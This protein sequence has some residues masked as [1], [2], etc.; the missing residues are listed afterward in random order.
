MRRKER[1]RK[2]G[3]NVRVREEDERPS[4]VYAPPYVAWFAPAARCTPSR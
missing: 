4:F 3:N 2:E 1:E